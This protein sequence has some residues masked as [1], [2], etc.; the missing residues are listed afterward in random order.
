MVHTMMGSVRSSRRRN[1][2]ICYITVDTTILRELA[3][4][5]LTQC[6]T[7]IRGHQAMRMET[8][9]GDGVYK[10][11]MNKGEL[12]EMQSLLQVQKHLI[13]TAV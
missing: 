2:L 12:R 10:E 6:H 13:H 1:T 11:L 5:N 4:Q 8:Q 9:L 7:I 3:W